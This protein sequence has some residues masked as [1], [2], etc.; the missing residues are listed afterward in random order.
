MTDFATRWGTYTDRVDTRSVEDRRIV[1]A[2]THIGQVRY[3]E[4][5]LEAQDLVAYM[6]E[7][8]VDQ[9]VLLPLESPEGTGYYLTTN[10][11]LDAAEEYPERIIPFCSVDPR[12]LLDE[13]GF[14]TV[15][16]R[17][18]DRGARGF[19]ELKAGVPIDDERMQLLYEICADK[20]LPVL[21]HLDDKCCT[22]DR[23]LPDLER[24]LQ[25][26]PE[27]PFIMHAH[28]WWA[29]ISA[30]VQAADMGTYPSDPVEPGGRCDELLGTYDNL[31]A[32]ISMGS[33]FN[34]ITRDVAYSQKFL[35]RH[36]EKLLFG[37]DFLYAGQNLPQFA[38][39][40]EF[41]LPEDAWKNIC[42]R[43]V[44]RLLR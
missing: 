21:F 29:H 7:Y 18:V 8:G 32:D 15:I 25:S 13:D 34:A 26:Y 24:M 40:D 4:R 6:D 41:D 3:T 2:H 33:G 42:H 5:P 36:H 14:R 10:E 22:D 12:M 9:S 27:V 28:G 30:G 39:F 23:G 11:V 35:E 20:G 31:Y 38:F 44:E 16:E 17:Y 37:T 43:N 19:G 1:D